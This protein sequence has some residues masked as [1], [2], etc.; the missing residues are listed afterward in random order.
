MGRDNN[1]LWVREMQSGRVRSRA[2][3]NDMSVDNPSGSYSRE[4]PDET[5]L[6]GKIRLSAAAQ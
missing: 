6:S 1:S 2:F 4:A 5:K 3:N